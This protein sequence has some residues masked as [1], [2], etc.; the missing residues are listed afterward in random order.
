MTSSTLDHSVQPRNWS[1]LLDGPRPGAFNMALDET[2]LSVASE[3]QACPQTYLRFYQWS[4]PTLS[5][6][7]AQRGESVVDLDFCRLNGIEIV[8]RPTGGKAVLHHHELTYSVVSND[9]SFFPIADISGTYC[10]IADAIQRGLRTLGIETTLAGSRGRNSGTGP[11]ATACFALSNHFELLC[12]NRKLVGSAQ[13]RTKTA[14]LQHGSILLEFDPL[15]LSRALLSCSAASMHDVVT[16]IRTCL[17]E[18]PSIHQIMAA[19][20]NGFE[21]SFEV[22]LA[23]QELSHDLLARAHQLADSKYARLRWNNTPSQRTRAIEA[24]S[25]ATPMLRTPLGK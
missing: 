23:H 3:P 8:R 6:G 17:G 22:R 1:V 7:F 5:L 24:R 2:L 4:R 16:D 11:L 10:R 12:Q 9:P 19:M 15:L 25:P 18:V 14:F 13:R 20:C 21:A